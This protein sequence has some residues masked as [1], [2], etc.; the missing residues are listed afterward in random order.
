[1]NENILIISDRFIKK[2]EEHIPRPFL[3]LLILIYLK[4]NVPFY[5]A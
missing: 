4:S 1:M 3:F 2:A 5:L